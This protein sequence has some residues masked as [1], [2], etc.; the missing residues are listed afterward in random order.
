MFSE[1]FVGF[2]AMTDQWK[3]IL[4]TSTTEVRSNTYNKPGLSVKENIF[5]KL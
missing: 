5:M 1:L 4:T 3:C 2:E